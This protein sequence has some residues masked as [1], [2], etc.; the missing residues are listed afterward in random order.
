MTH[1]EAI[2][3]MVNIL[4]APRPCPSSEKHCEGCEYEHIEACC[5]GLRALGYLA[6]NTYKLEKVTKNAAGGDCHHYVFDGPQPDPLEAW[7]RFMK[8]ELNV[9]LSP[10]WREK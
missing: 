9:E 2:V 5:E 6:E 10:D 8:A 7:E 1:R 4:G 3:N